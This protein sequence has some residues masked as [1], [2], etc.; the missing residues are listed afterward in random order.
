MTTRYAFWEGQYPFVSSSEVH[1]QRVD[2]AESLCNDYGY[3][4]VENGVPEVAPPV[5]VLEGEKGRDYHE[6]LQLCEEDYQDAR[7]EV[8]AAHAEAIAA[9]EALLEEAKKNR[10]QDMDRVV[11]EYRRRF[12][13]VFRAVRDEHD[14]TVYVR[15]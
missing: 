3:V 11:E 13:D 14:V 1:V 4:L 9:A 10:R 7:N 5:L 6:R 2:G 15:P 8:S 12:F